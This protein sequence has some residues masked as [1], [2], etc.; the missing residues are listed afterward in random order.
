MFD[1]EL[2]KRIEAACWSILLGL[3]GCFTLLAWGAVLGWI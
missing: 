3:L 1:P 2:A